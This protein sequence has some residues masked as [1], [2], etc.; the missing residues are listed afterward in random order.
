[1]TSST[2]SDSR[3]RSLRSRLTPGGSPGRYSDP[4]ERFQR[5]VTLGFI[6]LV[7]ATVVFVLLALVYG[8]WDANFRPVASVGGTGISRGANALIA[9]PLAT[10]VR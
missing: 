3:R 7:V 4:E 2:G 6:V 9:W 5:F 10:R 1:M 8:F